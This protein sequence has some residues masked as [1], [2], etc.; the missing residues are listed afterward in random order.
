MTSGFYFP[1]QFVWG[2]IFVDCGCVNLPPASISAAWRPLSSA[3][4]A[5]VG[6]SKTTVPC[7]VA[8]HEAAYPGLEFRADACQFGPGQS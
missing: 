2:G 1:V 4:S 7:A 8:E 5:A 3:P 6:A